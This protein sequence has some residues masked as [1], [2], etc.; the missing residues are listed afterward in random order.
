[1][2]PLMYEPYRLYDTLRLK[3]HEVI[4]HFDKN[5]DHANVVKLVEYFKHQR[6]TYM[7]MGSL[8]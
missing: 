3:F 6:K 4:T 2:P 8:K 7:I 1:M 5:S